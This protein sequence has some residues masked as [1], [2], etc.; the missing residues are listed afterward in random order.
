MLSVLATYIVKR[1]C[2]LSNHTLEL[3]FSHEETTPGGCCIQSL[4]GKVSEIGPSVRPSLWSDTLLD[5]TVLH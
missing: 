2:A 4:F 3:Y 5:P 1:L